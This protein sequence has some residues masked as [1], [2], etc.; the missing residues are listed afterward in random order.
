[1]TR[2]T[3]WNRIKAG[4]LASCHVTHGSQR[5]LYVRLE[6]EATLSLFESPAPDRQG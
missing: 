2:Q 6:E 1:M 5:G 4:Q 3:L